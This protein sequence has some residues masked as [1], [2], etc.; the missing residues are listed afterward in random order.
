MKNKETKFIFIICIILAFVSLLWFKG[1]N[2]IAGGDSFIPMAP[3]AILKSYLTLWTDRFFLGMPTITQTN[4]IFPYLGFW[5]LIKSMGFNLLTTEKMW[6]FLIVFSSG[7]SFYFL[8]NSF[9]PRLSSYAK[10]LSVI[11][12]TINPI[13]F[14]SYNLPANTPALVLIFI[15]LIL[16]LAHKIIETNEKKYIYLL[17]LTSLLTINLGSNIPLLVASLMPVTIYLIYRLLTNY[18]L[19]LSRLK[20]LFLA[21]FYSTLINSFW[22]IQFVFTFRKSDIQAV[23]N[24][25]WLIWTSVN[26]TITNILRF[27]GS[28]AFN[29]KAYDS[30]Y[31]TYHAL[32]QTHL[33][34]FI[35]IIIIFIMV[36]SIAYRAINKK[37]FLTFFWILFILAIA[38][39]KGPN[40][41]F[42]SIYIWLYSNTTL[43]SLFREPWTKFAPVFLLSSMVLF[44]YGIDYI[45]HYINKT[46]HHIKSIST[47]IFVVCGIILIMVSAYCKPFLNGSVIPSDRGKLPGALIQIPDYWSQTTDY[48]NNNH[49]ISKIMQLPSNPFYQIHL[50]WPNDGYYGVDPSIDSITKPIISLDPGGRYFA[51]NDSK[52]IISSVYNKIYSQD[53]NLNLTKIA[54]ILRLSHILVRNDLDWRHVGSKKSLNPQDILESLT[55]FGLTEAKSFGSIDTNSNTKDEFFQNEI[56]PNNSWVSSVPATQIFGINSSIKP[57][58]YSEGNFTLTN[59]PINKSADVLSM[60][61]VTGENFVFSNQN[62]NNSSLLNYSN[63]QLSLISK[64]DYSFIDK[65]YVA[66]FNLLKSENYNVYI[67]FDKNINND[68][69]QTLKIDDQDFGINLEKLQNDWQKIG[70]YNATNLEQKISIVTDPNILA[71]NNLIENSNFDSTKNW[72]LIDCGL[73]PDSKSDFNYYIIRNEDDN[74][75]RIVANNHIACPRQK[76]SNLDKGSV[77]QLSYEYRNILGNDPRV[78]IESLGPNEESLGVQNI[79]DGKNSDWTKKSILFEAKSSDLMLYL[80]ANAGESKTINDYKNIQLIK[81]PQTGIKQV[82]LVSKINGTNANFQPPKIS[83][84]KFNQW[85]LSY[86]MHVSSNN[87]ASYILN[88]MQSF[89]KSWVI[90]GV[91]SDNHFISNGYANG[92]VINKNGEYDITIYYGPQKLFLISQI[93]S[94]IIVLFSAYMLI[95]LLVNKRKDQIKHIN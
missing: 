94:L 28:W 46:Y 45:I 80:Y 35:S 22:L 40:P 67:N 7:F 42:G 76:I 75:L 74:F 52:E 3:W 37:S 8:I 9:A 89:D 24:T 25:D 93:I 63:E 71:S 5:S 18:R 92:W 15:P 85:L 59:A 38:L 21:L 81:L 44:A 65:D 68:S 58:F 56:L 54:S 30:F 87:N 17:A 36:I 91:K 1:N 84:V 14:F 57:L 51:P 41:P 95:R 72:Q 50:F 55:N 2:Y 77:Y 34:Q 23:Q 69:T 11:F 79:D 86:K 12:Y 4:A 49:E 33:Y 48:I 60:P 29:D 64:E 90:S 47:I 6:L 19:V 26:A 10:F 88:F 27:M 31:V 20:N 66:N 16:G 73:N 82:A 70:E 83:N 78:A 43:F 61:F 39:A 53:K 32:Y 62:K 13:V